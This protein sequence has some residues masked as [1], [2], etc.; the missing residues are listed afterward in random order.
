MACGVYN[1]LNLGKFPTMLW[2]LRG[3][4]VT[5]PNPDSH[6]TAGLDKITAKFLH[7]SRVKGQQASTT[8]QVFQP[9]D[10]SRLHMQW[11]KFVFYLSVPV[12]F[13]SIL[14]ASYSG[15]ALGTKCFWSH[16]EV[17]TLCPEC[18]YGVMAQF[19]ISNANNPPIIRHVN[20]FEIHLVVLY[21]AVTHQ[22]RTKIISLSLKWS[23]QRQG[24][25]L[26]LLTVRW[27]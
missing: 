26:Q 21:V 6:A 8:K 7:A 22:Q 10:P 15:C 14:N 3:S 5:R 1:T 13:F 25:S 23:P 4:D 17:L 12:H 18:K 19:L 9:Y 11:L 27:Q 16:G 2:G 20:D 24:P